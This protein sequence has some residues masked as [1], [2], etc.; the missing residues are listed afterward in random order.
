M[1]ANAAGGVQLRLDAIDA[2]ET[3]YTPP[4]S[5]AEWRQP[6]ALGD[7]A[8]PGCWTCWA[9]PRSS[10]FPA[11]TSP[12][13]PP[14]QP[15]A[16]SSPGSP[17]STAS[18]VPPRFPA[19]GEG[20]PATATRSTSQ[21]P[22]S[23]GLSTTSC[24]PWAGVPDVLLQALRRPARPA[25]RHRG[26]G[27]QGRHRRLGNDATLTG[28][29]LRSRAQLTDQLVILPKLFRR[30]AE[31]LALNETGNVSL[32]GS[33]RSWPRTTTGCLSQRRTSRPGADGRCVNG[34]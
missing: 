33:P 15:R 28:F 1:K 2:P 23:A 5:S 31:Y 20:G 7:G 9:S 10:G 27:P 12:P 13:P 6:P 34:S 4:H 17:T 16:T 21:C 25:G 29:T 19:A 14:R 11:A 18:A 22:N 3:D 24:S 26:R 30:L 8:R 32:A